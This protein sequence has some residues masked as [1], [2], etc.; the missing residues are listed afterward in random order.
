MATVWGWSAEGMEPAQPG[1]EPASYELRTVTGRQGLYWSLLAS[2]CLP[3]PRPQGPG[4]SAYLDGTCFCDTFF[5]FLMYWN[6][7]FTS[8][9]IYTLKKKTSLILANPII[10]I[11]MSLIFPHVQ[12]QNKGASVKSGSYRD[13]LN[14]LVSMLPGTPII[15]AGQETAC[16]LSSVGYKA[17]KV[18]STGS[19]IIII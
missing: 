4:W 11:F 1:K 14:M 10:Y 6:L 2:P 17:I 15:T 9:I 18:C 16:E 5:F 19:S 8:W 12:S 13:V 3:S 7:C